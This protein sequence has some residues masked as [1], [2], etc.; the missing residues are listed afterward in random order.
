MTVQLVANEHHIVGSRIPTIVEDIAEEHAIAH[1]NLKHLAIVVVL[2]GRAAP[3]H[4][5]AF[6][7]QV[8]FGLGN[9]MKGNGQT[10]TLTVVQGS[11]K[12]DAFDIVTCVWS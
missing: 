10:D 1:T 11:E 8:L 3:F 6:L 7:V 5:A 4:L 9:Q 2:G 12:V